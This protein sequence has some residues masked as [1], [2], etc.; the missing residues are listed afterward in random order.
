MDIIRA[1]LFQLIQLFRN[2]KSKKSQEEF[3]RWRVQRRK[4]L[5][6]EISLHMGS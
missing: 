6:S 4:K 3:L 5:E 1:K 2:L